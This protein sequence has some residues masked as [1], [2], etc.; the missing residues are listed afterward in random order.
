MASTPRWTFL[1]DWGSLPSPRQALRRWN[2]LNKFGLARPHPFRTNRVFSHPEVV[3]VMLGQ[4]RP[5]PQW[6][7]H[8]PAR[9]HPRGLLPLAPLRAGRSGNP[10]PAASA[11]CF[12]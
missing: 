9:L 10:G 11:D 5:P 3:V 7:R 2:L 8:H 1:P 12:Y 6:R 4:H